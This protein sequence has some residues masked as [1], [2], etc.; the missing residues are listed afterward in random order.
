MPAGQVTRSPHQRHLHYLTIFGVLLAALTLAWGH[1][2]RL[3]FTADSIFH[4]ALSLMYAHSLRLGGAEALWE[5]IRATNIS[6][7]P[8]TFIYNGALAWLISED[9][10]AVKLYGLLLLPLLIWGVYQLGRE[11]DGAL[12]GT[13]AAVL[14]IFS[15]GVACAVREVCIDYMTTLMV[16]LAML[17]L[18][19]AGDFSRPRGAAVVG[20]LFGLA[21]LTRVQ[22]LFFLAGPALYLAA[23]SLGRVS[24]GR[25]VRQRLLHMGLAIA[26]ALGIS[27]IYWGGRLGELLSMSA[28]HLDPSRVDSW[29]DP[30]FPGGLLYYGQALGKLAG[31]PVVLAALATL[32]LVRRRHG[33]PL[34]LLWLAGGILCY[35]LT[36]SREPRYLLP[37]VPA[38][39]LLAAMGLRR[40]PH[41]A[42]LSALL[43]LTTVLPTLALAGFPL[44]FSPDA[45]L[46]KVLHPQYVRPPDPDGSRR[47]CTPL[48]RALKQLLRDAPMGAGTYLFFTNQHRTALSVCL[49]PAFPNAILVS[50]QFDAHLLTPWSHRE[51]QRRRLLMISIGERSYDF[52][53]AWRWS[54]LRTPVMIYRVPPGQMERAL[55]ISGEE[56]DR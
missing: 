11:M 51:V 31:W 53:V 13:L 15:L 21:L 33:S 50:R 55:Q 5:S 39:A 54:L 10:R 4:H 46:G 48:R 41:Y 47:V 28:A 56:R 8:L 14:T 25:E 27:S 23:R 26:V 52:P 36:V 38:L 19:R 35:A 29:G 37:A 16:V 2:D 3:F 24:R 43:L 12:T 17:A 9:L 6:W 18:V 22:F 32:H 30:T 40:L 34:L 20:G 44:E 49:A 1:H 7:P 45:A 42:I